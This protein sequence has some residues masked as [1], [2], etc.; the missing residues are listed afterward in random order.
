MILEYPQNLVGTFS[1]SRAFWF[2]SAVRMGAGRHFSWSCREPSRPFGN[3]KSHRKTTTIIICS[4]QKH[5]WALHEIY[6]FNK[7]I[8]F[9]AGWTLSPWHRQK[10][11]QNPCKTPATNHLI[12]YPTHCCNMMWGKHVCRYRKNGISHTCGTITNAALDVDLLHS[13]VVPF[14]GTVLTT[15]INC[16]LI[17]LL[18]KLLR[19][20]CRLL[21]RHGFRWDQGLMCRLWLA[22]SELRTL[23]RMTTILL[24]NT[25]SVLLFVLFLAGPVSSNGLLKIQDNMS[26]EGE[27]VAFRAFATR[28]APKPFYILTDFP[29]LQ[30]AGISQWLQMH[31]HMWYVWMI[32]TLPTK[33]DNMTLLQ[34]KL[35]D[36]VGMLQ[37]GDADFISNKPAWY[38]RLFKET[39]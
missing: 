23:Q 9:L 29:I 10:G 14:L 37:F 25:C 15:R 24:W 4:P 36:T 18:P 2:F 38:D 27:F 32:D 17:I 22:A 11:I 34:R 7:S 6:C 21:P 28:S 20:E 39:S 30:H 3:R 31:R 35:N 1:T 13:Q 5:Y 16:C 8:H 33:N 12:S 26:R 19:I